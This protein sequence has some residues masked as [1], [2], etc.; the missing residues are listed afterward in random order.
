MKKKKT[1]LLIL[2]GFGVM[3]LGLIF[4][5]FGTPLKTDVAVIPVRG[6]I[7][8]GA[9]EASPSSVQN[10]IEEA[11]SEGAQ[12]F[13][14]EI[15]SP[16]GT[17][18]A[19]RQLEKTISN[20][21]EPTVCR[22]Q[23]YATSGA[24]WAASACDEIVTDPLTLTGGIGVI[25]SY[26][27]YSEFMEE[28]GIEYVRLTGGE[29]K[30]MGTPYRNITEEERELFT[31]ILNETHTDFIETVSE[32]RNLTED[33]A[34]TVGRGHVFTGTEAQEKRLTDYLGGRKKAKMIFEDSF[35]ETVNFKEYG[36][37]PGLIELLLG[38]ERDTETRDTETKME[39]TS[40]STE[41]EV[42]RL[43]AV[44]N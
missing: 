15:N 2:A 43:Y 41:M 20:I 6:G 4:M 40:H 5:N 21:E 29:L 28:E 3:F 10:N 30:D 39:E 23:D 1:V 9:V 13:L 33:Q 19:S 36:K 11:R 27:E 16:G 25:A 7:S 42:P 26:L 14:F 12:G 8:P 34:Q 22:F 18:V 44:S 38:A 35:N 31:R 24:Y 37:D 17:V 32:N